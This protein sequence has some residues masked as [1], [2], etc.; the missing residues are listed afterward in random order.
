V[1][2]PGCD[3]PPALTSKE[4][5]SG[6][7]TS[8]GTLD[9]GDTW[10]Y[11]CSHKTPTGGAGCKTSTVP[12][13]AD[14]AG[15]AGGA[16]VTDDDSITTTLYC[17]NRPKPPD[18]VQPVDP[19]NP[20][21]PVEP[22]GPTPPPAGNAADARFKFRAAI[23]SCLRTRVPHVSFEGTRIASVRVFVNG[24]LHRNLSVQTL[25]RSVTPHVTLPPGRYRVTARVTFEPGSGTPPVTFAGTV[26]ICGTQHLPAGRVP[27]TFTG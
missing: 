16:T 27:V 10:I 23:N 13:S 4:G 11:K 21:G 5:A 8:P 3:S 19:G 24:H 18:P 14:V 7:D 25:Q 22:T 20:A 15:S 2:D 17:R 6:P 26:R 12:N 9:P 1:T